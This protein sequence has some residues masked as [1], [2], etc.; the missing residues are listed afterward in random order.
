MRIGV[1]GGSFDPPT[2]SH[3][4]TMYT[5]AQRF[6]LD[7]VVILPCS[8]LRPDKNMKVSDDHRLY[9]LRLAM[10]D[11]SLFSLSQFEMQQES[12]RVFTYFTMKHFKEQ[13]S[14]SELFF[15]M[16]ADLLAD[17]AQ[18]YW[19]YGKELVESN[20]FI[21]SSR[22]GACLEDIISS[23]T[24]LSPYRDRF[25]LFQREFD[26]NISST[27]I[28]KEIADGRIPHWLLPYGVGNYIEENG[29]YRNNMV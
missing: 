3:F 25:H 28:R 2:I 10:T 15:L 16:G 12:S 22:E 29:L 19:D 6:H 11:S 1:F 24:F 23:S 4:D 20:Q 14:G 8:N 7:Q 17:I 5:L 9:M 27:Y 13:L 21:V 18:G 26:L